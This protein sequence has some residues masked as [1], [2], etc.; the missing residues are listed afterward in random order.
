MFLSNKNKQFLTVIASFL[1]IVFSFLFISLKLIDRSIKYKNDKFLH[2]KYDIFK[3]ELINDTNN[4]IKI[5]KEKLNKVFNIASNLYFKNKECY[6]Y[7]LKTISNIKILNTHF[8]HTNLN[9]FNEDKDYFILCT[10]ENN[11][12]LVYFEEKLMKLNTIFDKSKIKEISNINDFNET[13]FA[14][15]TEKLTYLFRNFLYN[16]EYKK[17]S[18]I[19]RNNNQINVYFKKKYYNSNYY[20]DEE[21]GFSIDNCYQFYLNNYYFCTILEE[22]KELL[23][24]RYYLEQYTFEKFI[25]N[26]NYLNEFKFNYLNNELIKNTISFNFLNFQNLNE[27]SEY[28]QKEFYHSSYDYLF[29]EISKNNYLSITYI[30]YL[31]IL[32]FVLYLIL[33]LIYRLKT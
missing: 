21:L 9:P 30:I 25:S 33:N 12:L 32:T 27:F 4:F 26:I 13:S 24:F 22:Y 1:L 31:F 11:N 14:I 7:D 28:R 10:Q 19:K 6:K 3:Y 5:K 29:F 2:E 17:Y 20:L 23:N 18:I 8:R 16:F 15:E